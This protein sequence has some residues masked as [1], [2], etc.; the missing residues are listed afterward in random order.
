MM[1]REPSEEA[2]LALL[3]TSAFLRSVAVA[4]PLTPDPW[5]ALA[6]GFRVPR[7]EVVSRWEELAGSG[8]IRG[9]WCEPNPALRGWQSTLTSARPEAGEL[10]WSARLRGSS[11]EA[12]A[13]WAAPGEAPAGTRLLKIG[14]PPVLAESVEELLGRSDDLTMRVEPMAPPPIPLG[15]SEAAVRTVLV[16]GLA[17]TAGTDLWI[18]IASAARVDP[19]TAS[20]AVRRLLMGRWIRRFAVRVGW[21]RAGWNG[22][23]LATWRLADPVLALQAGEALAVLR[24]VGDVLVEPDGHLKALFVAR[25]AGEGERAARAIAA[26]WP[27][28]SLEEFVPL[29]VD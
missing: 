27:A 9:I 20:T 7:A 11:G 14:I 25:G 3:D 28:A 17:V 10:R 2:H 12:L 15:P 13:A 19:A 1:T 26:Q 6:M 22:I 29:E 23:G 18:Q 8:V 24:G 4:L 16:E 21:E 5:E